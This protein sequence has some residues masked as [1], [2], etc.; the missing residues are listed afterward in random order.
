M[1][2]RIIRKNLNMELKKYTEIYTFYLNK[3]TFYVKYELYNINIQ[4]SSAQSIDCLLS[5]SIGKNV[6]MNFIKTHFNLK[7]KYRVLYKIIIYYIFYIQIILICCNL[8]LMM[9]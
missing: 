7:T 5:F 4:V 3:H 2:R 8:Y 9:S 6:F 1:F